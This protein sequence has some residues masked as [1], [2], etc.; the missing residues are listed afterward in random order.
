M[1]G[2][3][4]GKVILGCLESQAET[5]IRERASQQGAF[6]PASVPASKFLPRAPS[7][8]SLHDAMHCDMEV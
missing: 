1:G 3:A 2:A 7:L 5:A 6:L 8:A 4:P